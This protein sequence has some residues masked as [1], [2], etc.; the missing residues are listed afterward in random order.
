MG[1]GE[2]GF[3]GFYDFIAKKHAIFDLKVFC[4]YRTSADNVVKTALDIIR[5]IRKQTHKKEL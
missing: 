3:I 4:P 5:Q 2:E 1:V